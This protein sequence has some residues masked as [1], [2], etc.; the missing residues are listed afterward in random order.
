MK[1]YR[2]EEKKLHKKEQIEKRI[3]ER[4]EQKRRDEGRT[5]KRSQ[6]SPNVRNDQSGE[7]RNLYPQTISKEQA[8]QLIEVG[9]LSNFFFCVC[10]V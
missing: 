8:L 4:N 1:R 6:K 3:D 2:R 9:P 5:P 10:D 7:K